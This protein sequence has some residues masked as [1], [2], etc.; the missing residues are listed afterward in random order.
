MS[1][2]RR[3]G[4]PVIVVL[5]LIAGFCVIVGKTLAGVLLLAAAAGLG[6]DAAR[7]R[8]RPAAPAAA[9][10]SAWNR[11][12]EGQRGRDP[13][14]ASRA[15]PFLLAGLA[16]G[17]LYAWVVGSFARYSW[18][19]TAAV[20]GLAVIVVA[21][22]WRGPLRS[23]PV[24]GRLPGRGAALWAG[25]IAAGSA[26]ELAAFFQQPGLRTASYAHP[27]ISVL[28]DPLLAS[29]AGRSAAL[30]AWLAIG[31]FLVRR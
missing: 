9:A 20:I 30:A 18:P 21:I 5:L 11:L 22:G 6:W 16:A 4:Q 3:G 8:R 14:T 12:P 15:P 2:R 1:P 25:L 13:A 27:T 31:W 10:A 19:A 28:T 17:I 26:W 23:R 7:T 24:P 29:H